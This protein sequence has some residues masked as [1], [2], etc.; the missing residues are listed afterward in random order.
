MEK[1]RC[2][3][4]NLIAMTAEEYP[5]AAVFVRDYCSRALMSVPERNFSAGLTWY[6]L[7][8]DIIAK[9]VERITNYTLATP[10][11]TETAER[12]LHAYLRSTSERSIHACR[13]TGIDDSAAAAAVSEALGLTQ[14]P[15][16]CEV[17]CLPSYDVRSGLKSLV[18]VLEKTCRFTP[19]LLEAF[20][21]AGGYALLLRLLDTCSED[22]IP[23]LLDIADRSI[24][25]STFGARNVNAFSTMR[26][27]LLNY[28]KHLVLQL[29]TQVLHIY[30]SDYD[31]F[32][33]LEPKT[34]TLALLLTKLPHTSFYDTQ[35]IILRIVE[36][37]C[38]AAKPEDSLP[39]EILSVVCGG[40]SKS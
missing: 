22:E 26:D 9:S 37:V 18:Y 36:Y 23:A 30:T 35:V 5:L 34:R 39:H 16:S 8:C 4:P 15:T 29:L 21:A 38:C 28:I 33:F 3:L 2:E 19:V 12:A 24:G 32:V 13:V 10:T 20:Q 1:F 14:P 17:F 25:S 27:L 31:N 7:D 6:L 40:T 11:T